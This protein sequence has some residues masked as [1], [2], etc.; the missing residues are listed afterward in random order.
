MWV[1]LTI[2]TVLTS[3]FYSACGDKEY[4][5]NF[6]TNQW[7]LFSF[8]IMSVHEYFLLGHAEDG[9][10]VVFWRGQEVQ[11]EITLKSIFVIRG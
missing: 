6:K 2:S 10:K 8:N 11:D 4:L 9:M 7:A 3:S 5:E 1:K